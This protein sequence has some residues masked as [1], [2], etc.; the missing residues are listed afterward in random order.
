MWTIVLALVGLAAVAAGGGFPAEV[1]DAL[2][3][4]K[5]IYVAT[6]RAD[7]SQSKVAPVWFMVDGD[8]VL[9]TTGPDSHKVRRIRRGSPLLVWVGRADGP[10]FT[11]RAEVLQDPE[12][13]ARMAPVYAAKYWI[14]W[15]GLFKPN[16]DRVRA[17][18][19]V[20]V[21]VRPA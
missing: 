7:G 16:P 11:G 10:H 15:L 1:A 21:R 13:A 4:A 6:R 14:A 2:R 9:F 19:T 5:Q 3:S 8:A 18:K 20:I 17:G 12:L